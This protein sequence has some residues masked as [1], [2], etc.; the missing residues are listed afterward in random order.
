MLRLGSQ[1]SLRSIL[2]TKMVTFVYRE[3]QVVKAD[4]NSVVCNSIIHSDVSSKGSGVY[5]VTY[6][7]RVHGRHT[8]IVKVNGT[9][10]A[11]SPLQV[12]VKIDPTHLGKPVRPIEDVDHLFG[13]ALNSRYELVVAEC[14]GQKMT[15]SDK[16]GKKIHK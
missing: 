5:E 3:K 14:N 8:L 16:D 1:L 4:L 12:F 11:G 13:I 6:T 10:I 9:Q 7:P 15:V 2:C